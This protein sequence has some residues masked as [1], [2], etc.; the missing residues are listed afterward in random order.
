[1]SSSASN[2]RANASDFLNI[3]EVCTSQIARLRGSRN[4][5][6]DVR[7][8]TSAYSADAM[9]SKITLFALIAALTTPFVLLTPA[10]SQSQADELP[11]QVLSLLN[12]VQ[13]QQ[14]AIVANQDQIDAKIATIAEEVRLARIFVSR[15]GAK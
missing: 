3:A 13:Q 1:V 2:L 6:H 4:S 8:T 11:P 9:K 5:E 15:A 12:E 10:R 7:G 14:A